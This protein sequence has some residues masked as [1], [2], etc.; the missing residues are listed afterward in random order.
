MSR[1]CC[2]YRKGEK[3]ERGRTAR[4]TPSWTPKHS[5]KFTHDDGQFPLNSDLHSPQQIRAF[6]LLATCAHDEQ[7]MW[8]IAQR[9]CRISYIYCIYPCAVSNTDIHSCRCMNI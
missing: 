1:R 7:T 9:A 2:C 3:N 5:P 8:P 4:N 6:T